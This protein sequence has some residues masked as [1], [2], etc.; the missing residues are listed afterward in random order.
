MRIYMELLYKFE[1][2]DFAGMTPEQARLTSLDS[3]KVIDR[4]AHPYPYP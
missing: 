2:V 1:C 3:L 4:I